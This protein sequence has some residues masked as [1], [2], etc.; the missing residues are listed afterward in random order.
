LPDADRNI[1]L[2]ADGS[3]GIRKPASGCVIS[4]VRVRRETFM[5]ARCNQGYRA[6]ALTPVEGLFLEACIVMPF[7]TVLQADQYSLPPGRKLM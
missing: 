2:Y 1:L 4:R 5:L 7:V 3:T 6:S